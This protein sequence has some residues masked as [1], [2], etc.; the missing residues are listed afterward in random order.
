VGDG[1]GCRRYW[2]C[3]G[4][5]ISAQLT[6][7]D[8]ELYVLDIISSHLCRC[9]LSIFFLVFDIAN[10][11]SSAKAIERIQVST[12]QRVDFVHYED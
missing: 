8:Y 2:F 9:I 5:A 4:C 11:D 7:D 3:H 10:F 12:D 1:D 6:T